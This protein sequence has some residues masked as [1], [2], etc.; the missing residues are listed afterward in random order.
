MALI[1]CCRLPFR[2]SLKWTVDYFRR[3]CHIIPRLYCTS[4]TGNKN[5]YDPLKALVKQRRS[6]ARRSLLV[7]VAGVKSAGDLHQVCSQYGNVQRMFHFTTWRG[8]HCKE[9]IL[10]EFQ[11]ASSLAEALADTGSLDTRQVI[12]ACSPLVWLAAQTA[13]DGDHQQVKRDASSLVGNESGVGR[14]EKGGSE[15]TEKLVTKGNTE[16]VESNISDNEIRDT[17]VARDSV[18][19]T[20]TKD[21]K[22]DSQTVH[23]G[24]SQY[25]SNFV[26]NSLT[27]TPEDLV[28][29]LY[30]CS[31]MSEQIQTLYDSQRLSELGWRLRF[32]SCWQVEAALSGLFPRASVLP[33]GS[34]INSFGNLTCDLDMNL[35]LDSQQSVEKPPRLM[36]QAKKRGGNQ[37]ST[38]LSL[39]RH[40]EVISDLLH[41][42]MPGCSQVRKILNAKVPIIKYRHDL[43][44]LE[45]DLSL[46]NSSG[47]HMSQLLYLYGE[48][49]PRVRPL[50]FAVRRWALDRH[51]TSPFAGRWITNF[52]LT[53]LVLFYLTNVQVI[54]SL[55]TLGITPF[56]PT[57][58]PE[59]AYFLFPSEMQQQMMSSENK[60]SLEEL[61]RGFFEFYDCFNFREQGLS[62]L[63]GLGFV[64]P[65]HRAMYI[66]NPLSR[67]LNVSRNVTLEEV[68]RIRT[69]ITNARYLLEGS[70]A[71]Q[72]DGSDRESAWGA[73]PLWDGFQRPDPEHG[74]MKYTVNWSNLFVDGN[75]SQKKGSS[76]QKTNKSSQKTESNMVT[77]GQGKGKKKNNHE[78]LNG[79]VSNLKQ[80]ALTKKIWKNRGVKPA[81]FS[82]GLGW[83]G[84]GGGGEVGGGGG[85]ENGDDGGGGGGEVGDDGGGEVGGDD[86]C[87]GG[88]VGGEVG[89]DGC[90]T[91]IE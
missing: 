42:F 74:G 36:Y 82:K 10:V 19:G 78:D 38:R 63:H 88:E 61:L 85:G 52:S 55:S 3:G 65:E 71:L 34:S 43:T 27:S 60:D 2:I 86:G 56:N 20:V 45:C 67:E 25:T 40:L 84:D 21:N 72:N 22:L 4:P 76:S 30:L 15:Y 13:S 51:L 18:V 44:D 41:C 62:L 49:D 9:M 14:I 68:D 17:S 32:F 23:P 57:N 90:G 1:S 31:D 29:S 73:L 91:K 5:Y 53:L 6:E 48:W 77:A 64:K 87:G 26:T 70:K 35:E 54:P 59:D 39:Q 24:P 66:Q 28:R 83:D 8:T 33:F 37:S 58:E 7:E 12:P 69:E 11:E 89:D 47:Y 80:Q 46:G 75:D 81:R 50:V 16:V 79:L